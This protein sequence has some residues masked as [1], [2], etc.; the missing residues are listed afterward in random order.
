MM[1]AMELGLLDMIVELIP[2]SDMQARGVNDRAA[3]D[4]ASAETRVFAEGWMLAQ[5][6]RAQLSQ[7]GAAKPGARDSMRI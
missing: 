3:M 4:Y 6:E 1:F 7:A 5:S 2:V